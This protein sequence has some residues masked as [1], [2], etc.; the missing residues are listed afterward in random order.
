MT[1]DYLPRAA[2]I[3]VDGGVLAF[4]VALALAVTVLVSVPPALLD[5][6]E[7][8]L[9]DRWEAARARCT[10]RARARARRARRRAGVSRPDAA[11]RRQHPRGWIPPPHATRSRA[12]GP[13]N[14]LTFRIELPG[15][16]YST[17]R[18]IEFIDRL[19]ERLEAVPGV[20]SATVGHAAAAD[21]QRDVD[22]VQ[23]RGASRR[24]ERAAILEHGDRVA[25]YFRTI[26]T[27][28]IDG[29]RFTDDDDERH[30]RVLVVNKAFADRFF[31][32]EN[33]I[34]KRIASGATS[35]RDAAAAAT[36]SARSSASSATP[37]RS[38]G[39]REPEPIYYFP[40]KQMPWGPPSV[41]VRDDAPRRRR[42]CPTSAGSSPRSIRRCR[43]TASRR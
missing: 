35:N 28:I 6:Q 25:G 26:G 32:G 22:L 9:A 13:D 41:I 23:H 7:R 33:A 17:D 15:A 14:L 12:S 8:R 31:P 27:P 20:T 24:S 30:P 11:L 21:R 36:S 1:A 29:T 10:R 42:S 5:R 3:H 40:Y 34:G 4:T 18:Q 19:L 37:A 39:G 16:R 38:P 43:C 2:D